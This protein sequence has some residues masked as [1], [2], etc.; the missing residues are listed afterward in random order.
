MEETKKIALITGGNKGIGF[1]VGRQLAKSGWTVLV[2]ARNEEIGRKG[3]AKLR[4]DGL[5][6]H[7][8]RIDLDEHQTAKTASAAIQAHFGKLISSS[9]TRGSSEKATALRARQALRM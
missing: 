9:T 1:E 6:V 4:A 2:A 3:V 7:F 5:D 8:V